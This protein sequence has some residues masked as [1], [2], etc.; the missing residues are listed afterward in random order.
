MFQS[1]ELIL[2]ALSVTLIMFKNHLLNKAPRSP[3]SYAHVWDHY[4]KCSLFID[5]IENII[6]F[7]DTSQCTLDDDVHVIVGR[8]VRDLKIIQ[9]F[10]RNCL[11]LLV[12]GTTNS[13]LDDFGPELRLMIEGL[14]TT[15]CSVHTCP[16]CVR[17]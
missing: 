8:F 1:N 7:I 3:S 2:A 13:H 15:L 11:I 9:D 17:N 14:Y 10:I 4:R 12:P 6:D 16:V 5:N